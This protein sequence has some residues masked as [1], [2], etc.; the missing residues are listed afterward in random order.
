MSNITYTCKGPHLLQD[1]SMIKV[2]TDEAGIALRQGCGA[3]LTV[4]IAAVP[5]DGKDHDV[6]CPKCKNVS[7]VMKGVSATE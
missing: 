5:A 3:D 4:L 1:G 6:K 7:S 2:A